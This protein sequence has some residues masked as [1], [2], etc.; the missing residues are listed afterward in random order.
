MESLLELFCDVDDFCQKFEPIWRK[1]LFGS[2]ECQR[3]RDRSLSM[4]EMMTIMIHFHQSQ[5]R[6]FKAYYTEHVLKHLQTEFPTLVSYKRFVDFIP[7]IL[8]PLSVYLR[9]ACFGRCTGFSFVDSTTLDVCHNRRIAQHRVFKGLAQRGKNSMGWFFGFKLHLIVNDCGEILNMKLTPGNIDDRA[10][11]PDL[12]RGL[13]G[14]LVGD[15]GYISQT[16]FEEFFRHSN[17]QLIT[18]IKSNMKN[19][20]MSVFDKILLRK[21]SIIETVIDQ[22]K[23]ISQIEHSRHRSPNNFLVNL[24]CGLIA[25]CRQPKKPSLGFRTPVSLLT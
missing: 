9:T 21:R 1:R 3:Q 6:N 14:K 8:M 24:I 2:G 25:Y 11:V 12:A 7:T 5:Y 4:S 17:I 23:N 10:P 22:L 20:L 19:K 18:G 16:L 15:K 13:F